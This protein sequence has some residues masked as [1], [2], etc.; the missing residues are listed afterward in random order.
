MYHD[1]FLFAQYSSNACLNQSLGPCSTFSSKRNF[2]P[3]FARESALSLP[4]VPLWALT[5]C[6]VTHLSGE[7]SKRFSQRRMR[8]HMSE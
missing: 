5:Y 3:N 6:T 2:T 8:F 7:A 4:T 1:G